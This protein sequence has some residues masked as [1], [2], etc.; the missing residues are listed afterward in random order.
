MGLEGAASCRCDWSDAL[1]GRL[2]NHRCSQCDCSRLHA[3]TY[4]AE[5]IMQDT[6]TKTP[7]LKQIMAHLETRYAHGHLAPT[8]RLASKPM[9]HNV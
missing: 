8:H 6:V 9:Q 5:S 4:Q 1:S 3:L 2:G 7:K